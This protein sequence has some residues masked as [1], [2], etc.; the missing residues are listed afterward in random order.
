[1]ETWTSGNSKGEQ[2]F[3]KNVK[4]KIGKK[5]LSN[6]IKTIVMINNQNINEFKTWKKQILKV[7][8]LYTYRLL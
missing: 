8:V 7:T 6:Q 4:I 1:M 3:L 5:C 2:I